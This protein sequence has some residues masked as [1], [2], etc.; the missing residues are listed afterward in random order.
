[1]L[2]AEQRGLVLAIKHPPPKA[3]HMF[4]L[5]VQI[6]VPEVCQHPLM[7]LTQGHVSTS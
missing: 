3:P 7:R 5:S 2:L 6:H 4:A 1:V